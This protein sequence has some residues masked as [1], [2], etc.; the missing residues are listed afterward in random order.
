[1]ADEHRRQLEN[2]RSFKFVETI[3]FRSRNF[4]MKGCVNNIECSVIS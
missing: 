3:S 1:M 2:N 4:Y